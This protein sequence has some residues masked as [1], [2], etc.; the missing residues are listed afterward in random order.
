MSNSRFFEKYSKQIYVLLG[1]IALIGII[2]F[3]FGWHQEDPD[4]YKNISV[5]LIIAWVL[6]LV[7]Y[8]TWALHFYNVNYGWTDA[9]WEKNAER[10]SLT[11]ELAEKEPDGNPHAGE[12]LG[13]PPGTI[14]GTIALSLLVTGLSM[15]IA[16]LSMKNT[17]PAD[18][19]FVD[20]FEFFKT[21]FLMMIAFYFGV[22]G[23]EILDKSYK[24]K[25]QPAPSETLKSEPAKQE[26]ILPAK[27]P[28]A[29]P[30]IEMNESGGDQTPQ[31]ASKED[32]GGA[33]PA[34][35]DPM[36]KG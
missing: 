30:D 8:Y 5:A 18:S 1:F 17:Y 3:L 22:K 36:A 14:R 31:I 9:E 20:N 35:H 34:F 10:K 29:E 26:P 21:A 15:T 27:E 4:H 7:A 24:T 11:P 25:E 12:S 23:L 19:V 33:V 2:T 16:S 13:L 32:V 28:V 6:F